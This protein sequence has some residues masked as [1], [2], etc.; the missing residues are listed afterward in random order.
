MRIPI[1]TLV[2]S[3][4]A[5]RQEGP[6][7]A[8]QQLRVFLQSVRDYAFITF[9]LENHITSWSAGAERILGWTDAEA[10]GQPG[11]MLF[12][13]EDRA[14]GA[15]ERELRTAQRDG[16]AEDDRWHIR[17]D[18]SRF[19]A[20]GVMTVLRDEAERQLGFVK[21]LRDLTE[22]RNI[23]SV[24][25]ESEARLKADL[26]GMRRLYDLRARLTNETDLQAALNE[27]LA[28]AIEFSGTDRG[29]VQL[30]SEDGERLDFVAEIGHAADSPFIEYF[31]NA[32]SKPACEAARGSLRRV[33]IEDVETS[34][35][36][37]GTVDRE[38]ALEDGV[39]AA[40]LT[41][42]IDR[43]GDLLGVL[44]TQFREPHRP[45]EDELRL[46]DLLAWTAAEFVERRRG[47]TALRASE[48]RF[49]LLVDNVR[50]Y[51]LFQTDREGNITSWNPGAERLFG[52]TK[53]EMIGASADRLL[54]PEDQRAGVFAQEIARALAGDLQ[55]D[56]RWMVRKN[57]SQFWAQ[58]ITEPVCDETGQ[59]RGVA[60]VLRDE[61][62][63]QETEQAL[64]V[65][66]A[67]KEALLKEI[68]HRV[69]NNLQVIVSL[70]S[71]Q[72]DQI[73]DRA[74]LEMFHDTQSRV[75]SIA[76]I[77][78]TLYSSKDLA[79]IEFGQYTRMLVRDLFAF[80]NISTDRIQCDIQTEDMA[81][82]ITQAIPLGLIL[83][84]L[85][86]NCLKH[87]FPN[88]RRGTIR[89][90]LRYANEEIKPG[91]ML[92]Q[93]PGQLCVEDDG[94]GLP[95]DFDLEHSES[96]GMY[97]VRI[98]TRQCQGTLTWESR[99]GTRICVRFPLVVEEAHVN[100]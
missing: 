87:A 83:N 88:G 71:L 24:L 26:V 25:R 21:V 42:M 9:D 60:K 10:L 51:A 99:Q 50:E 37:A 35:L 97:L 78:E 47:E 68:H 69:K 100:V 48:E 65:S 63:R 8:E 4:S 39:R 41:P 49:R 3:V 89:V 82:S 38:V 85:V 55:Q 92:D 1:S 95:G 76:R 70:L 43:K 29:T 84:E 40:Q 96:M 46:I 62:E 36:L 28:A 75:R 98:L 11:A 30:V 34:P 22:R 90:C 15:V 44:S 53:A 94:A 23:E 17:K 2:R 77:H 45:G 5:L 79:E 33:I 61:T 20:S 56:A 57:G 91:E 6:I 52:H 19:W 59:L 64:R 14:I 66:L 54:T 18:G 86:V 73:T 12:T 74:T 16:R 80:Y 72:A 31:S 93:V 27:I 13:P 81:L 7:S 58:W 67:E 32:G